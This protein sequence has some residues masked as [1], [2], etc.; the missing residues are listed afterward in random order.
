V[1]V[2]EVD[3]VDAEPLQAALTR[4]A[5]VRRVAADLAL[6]VGERE[7]ELGYQLH[8]L[9]HPA[10]QRLLAGVT[11][12]TFSERSS[13]PDGTNRHTKFGGQS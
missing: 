12:S 8:L 2:V 3:A 4:R 7:A 1:L 11:S 6:A 9:P 10:L 5:H 13:K